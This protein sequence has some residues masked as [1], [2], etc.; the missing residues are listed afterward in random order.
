MRL[1]G[2]VTLLLML[3]PHQQG[4]PT[5]CR[6]DDAFA[7]LCLTCGPSTETVDMQP[8]RT[9]PSLEG[10]APLPES[11]NAVAPGPP[12]MQQTGAAVAA[13]AQMTAAAAAK[14]WRRDEHFM[15]NY[16]KTLPCQRRTRHQWRSCPFV[17]AGEAVRRR[18]LAEVPYSAAMCTFVRLGQD[19]P[20]GDACSNVR[21]RAGRGG[22]WGERWGEAWAAWP[23]QVLLG[24]HAGT[25]LRNTISCAATPA[26]QIAANPCRRTTFLSSG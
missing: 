9:A 22:C 16:F 14:N 13:S 11:P 25:M 18:S 1:A 19:C 10:T 3:W 21:G 7:P 17:H 4:Y 24:R 2:P 20:A 26:C 5:L 6:Q 23:K 15:L 8:S 12:P